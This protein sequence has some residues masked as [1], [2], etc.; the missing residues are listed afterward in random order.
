[1]SNP[2]L[3][4]PGFGPSSADGLD[5]GIVGASTSPSRQG[6][7]KS[8]GIAEAPD[9]S[10]ELIVQQL[11]DSQSHVPSS[12]P[13]QTDGEVEA[14]TL[15]VAEV[16]PVTSALDGSLKAL[17]DELTPTAE[18]DGEA[19]IAPTDSD[20]QPGEELFAQPIDALGAFLFQTQHPALAE[21][22]S[23]SVGDTLAIGSTDSSLTELDGD[24]RF[25]SDSILESQS[26]AEVSSLD[27]LASGVSSDP[28]TASAL[29]TT[30]VSALLLESVGGDTIPSE[31]AASVSVASQSN[32]G[33]FAAELSPKFAELPEGEGAQ[34]T[35]EHLQAN[36]ILASS[37]QPLHQANG[38]NGQLVGAPTTAASVPVQVQAE[39]LVAGA[40]HVTSDI[41]RPQPLNEPTKN[42]PSQ[43]VAAELNAIDDAERQSVLAPSAVNGDSPIQA[44]PDSRRTNEPVR[45]DVPSQPESL[46]E[47]DPASSF[48]DLAETNFIDETLQVEVAEQIDS[49]A[50]GIDEATQP[51]QVGSTET[52]ASSDQ[53]DAGQ[54]QFGTQGDGQSS[55]FGDT[56]HSNDADDGGQSKPTPE[57]EDRSV[58]ESSLSQDIPDALEPERDSRE[59]RE[60]NQAEETMDRSD[61][62]GTDIADAFGIKEETPQ[63]VTTTRIAEPVSY[64]SPEATSFGVTL[65]QDLVQDT[66]ASSLEDS[67]LIM[68]ET[69]ALEGLQVESPAEDSIRSAADMIRRAAETSLQQDGRTIQLELSPAELGALKIQVIQS[70]HSIETQIVAAEA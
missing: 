22:G 53:V 63:A 61:I 4:F 38:I 12:G 36:S 3:L 33:S 67:S 21:T 62:V 47:L 1:M 8:G 58:Q 11:L 60:G 57:G 23:E 54:S 45:A 27:E 66:A 52:S 39:P 2:F 29:G 68:E 65:S 48:V 18:T 51:R 55:E 10:F 16:E 56:A 14:L 19:I 70:E 46:P 69:L 43:P 9:V 32:D 34:L 28:Q 24:D 41:S 26:L 42:A 35:L 49:V 17:L 6:S 13:S 50:S 7:S 15:P 44:R 37:S 40:E 25:L 59:I 20:A 31:F 30:T 64:L 5:S